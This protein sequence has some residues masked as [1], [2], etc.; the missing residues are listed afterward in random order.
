MDPQPSQ[1][2]VCSDDAYTLQC[3]L[4]LELHKTHREMQNILMGVR[5]NCAEQRVL[6]DVQKS[7]VLQSQNPQ[8]LGKNRVN[9]NP[10]F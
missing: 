9:S 3:S 6:E 8:L 7:K 1:Q 5:Q 4:A 10:D 2:Q